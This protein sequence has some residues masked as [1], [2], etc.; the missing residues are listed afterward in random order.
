MKDYTF[1]TNT[2]VWSRAHQ[3]KLKQ[4]PGKSK[5][6][7][8]YVQT[9]L[10]W[11]RKWRLWREHTNASIQTWGAQQTREKVWNSKQRSEPNQ[12][13]LGW[14][15]TA[16][17]TLRGAS[18]PMQ[19]E[20]SEAQCYISKVVYIS[21]TSELSLSELQALSYGHVWPALKVTE[22]SKKRQQPARSHRQEKEP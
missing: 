5:C 8:T 16:K 10:M 2:S 1:W 20:K 11:N 17:S 19:K 7:V 14:L 12:N 15:L 9:E 6:S 22:L 21:V 13:L 18:F 3:G 4:L